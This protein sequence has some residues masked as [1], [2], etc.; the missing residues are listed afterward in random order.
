MRI[1]REQE[2][3]TVQ[4]SISG[5]N[6]A[7]LEELATL[8]E[9]AGALI[10]S[11]RTAGM[12][13]EYKE[14]RSPVTH[15]DEAA[16]QLIVERL[17]LL[18]PDV[19]VISEEGA[20]LAAHADA[21][22]FWL[23][24]P[25]DGTKSFIRGEDDF[26][27]NIALIEQRRPVAGVIYIPAR[28]DGYFGSDQA[29][30]FHWRGAQ[31]TTIQASPPPVGGVRAVVSRHHGDPALAALLDG[32]GYRL[33]E[34]RQAASSLKF[35]LV[36]EGSADLYPRLGPTMEWDTA[37]GHAIL[38]AAGGQMHTL[39]GEEFLYGKEEY[40][41]PGFVAGGKLLLKK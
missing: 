39:Q 34:T 11:L 28:G 7:F 8:A 4:R 17:E 36:A 27:V 9:A 2:K 26:T 37:A 20:A 5:R 29:G 15:A 13:V 30:A 18:Y 35:C 16:N 22:R 21:P 32:Y 23:V 12:A 19:P 40:R 14:D 33:A 6:H 41:N 3:M 24:D 10:L 25:L 31:K 1:E 38:L